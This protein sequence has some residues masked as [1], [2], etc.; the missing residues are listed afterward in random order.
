MAEDTTSRDQATEQD[1][2]DPEDPGGL[3][4][5]AARMEAALERIAKQLDTPG[6]ARPAAELTARLDGL[7]ARLRDVLATP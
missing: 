1:T 2:S 5:V 3:D 6:P 4:A 7:I